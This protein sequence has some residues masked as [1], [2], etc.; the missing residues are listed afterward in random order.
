MTDGEPPRKL[1]DDISKALTDELNR[2]ENYV[3]GPG[4]DWYQWSLIDALG[5]VGEAR[6]MTQ[7]TYV[8]DALWK[9][10]HDK[11]L[12]WHLRTRAVRSLGQLSL[13]ASFNVHLLV[14]EIVLLTGQMSAT[15]NANPNF[16]FWTLCFSDVYFAFK[17]AEA[18]QQ[19]RGW[20]LLQNP[21]ANARQVVDGA[22]KQVLPLVNAVLKHDKPQRIP[23]A[24]FGPVSEW[25]KANKPADAKIH[26][27]AQ[28][29]VAREPQPAAP[30]SPDGGNTDVAQPANGP[31]SSGP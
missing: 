21:P 13:D 12:P 31:A 11:D 9:T 10:M 27:N 24:L 28:P 2:I 15:Y 19:A 14:H 6:S 16:S 25:Q 26:Q 4:R 30:A 18:E 20:G 17:A 8:V 22:Y 3:S 23:G 5:T 29:L 1:R 7:E